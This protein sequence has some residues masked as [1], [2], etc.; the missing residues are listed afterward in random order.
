MRNPPPVVQRKKRQGL[1]FRKHPLLDLQAREDKDGRSVS[2]SENSSDDRDASDLSC[3]SPGAN[4][5]NAE[6]HEYLASL[7]SQ[8]DFPTPVHKHRHSDKLFEGRELLA[9]QAL[10]MQRIHEMTP[11]QRAEYVKTKKE[12]RQVG[13]FV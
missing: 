10:S 8:N 3:V 7:Q 1:A 2:R 12:K 5:S 13:F 4:L 11:T 6:K 9:A